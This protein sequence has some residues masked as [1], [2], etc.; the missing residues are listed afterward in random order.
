VSLS[1]RL[2]LLGAV[3]ALVAVVAATW[4]TVR[5]TTVAVHEEQQESLHADAQTYDALVGYSATHRS[6][7]AA[8]PLVDRLA[9]QHDGQVTVTDTTGRVLVS[10][11]DEATSDPLDPGQARARID[12]LD[13]DTTLLATAGPL[14][15][16]PSAGPVDTPCTGA[17]VP[18]DCLDA[19][20][21]PTLALDSRVRTL[22]GPAGDAIYEG[23]GPK[24]NA[25]LERA[26]LAPSATVLRSLS[27][28]VPYADHQRRVERCLDDGLRAV[29]TPYVAPPA[30]LHVTGAGSSAEVFWDLSGHNQRRILLLAGG[31]LLV[32]LLVCA[33]LAATIVVPL[34]RLSA[35]ALRAGD[36]DLSARVP[37]GRRD[38]I[39]R[40]AR[41]FNRMAD[42][43][44]Q[45][46]EARR[47][48]VSDVSHELR[49]PLANVRGWVEA[50]RDGVVDAD[51]ELM[52]SLL[53]ES[54]HLQR[55]VDDL[56]DLAL[57]DAGELRL[58]R[59]PV[60]LRTFLEQ[61]ATSFQAAAREAGLTLAVDCSR[62][63][64]VVADPVRLRQAT[65]NL[66]ANAIR[67][68][69]A[70]GRVTLGGRDGEV[71]VTDTGEGIP[72]DELAHVFDRFRRVDPSRTR[73]TGGSGL[74]LAIVRQ[75]AEAHGGTASARSEVGRGTTVTLSLP[76]APAPVR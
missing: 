70:G 10:S 60:E 39:G 67:H 8:Q 29:L 68:T 32:T 59:Q 44:Q 52:G 5:A 42:R 37:E 18:S 73:A 11:S 61:V 30:L 51:Q 53:E 21:A 65:T 54:L 14:Q 4:A 50:A 66:V 64:R 6:W 46:E 31:V 74:G 2:F 38:E 43:R 69:P 76:D 22:D 63:A 56:H 57:A 36:G 7:S 25:C 19:F 48:M 72:A 71:E 34:R 55:L 9:R 16:E 45:L 47:R 26:G 35:A 58:E 24:V 33:L 23:L 62:A 41:A 13:V 12:P 28:S 1:V 17:T 20:V 15:Q 75:L 27:V 3:I 49:T 40:L